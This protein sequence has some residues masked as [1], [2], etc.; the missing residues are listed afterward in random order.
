M[1]NG[2]TGTNAYTAGK[3]E[4]G[5]IGAD[6]FVLHRE[7][8]EEIVPYLNYSSMINFFFARGGKDGIKKEASGSNEL[9]HYEEDAK[10]TVAVVTGTSTGGATAGAAATFTMTGVGSGSTWLQPFF[11]NQI[12]RCGSKAAGYVQA[13][14]TAITVDNSA[15]EHA[16]TVKPLKA[17]N[18]LD[19]STVLAAGQ[20]VH[21]LSE[22]T[23]DGGQA[24]AGQISKLIRYTQNMHQYKRKVVQY[25]GERSNKAMVNIDGGNYLYLRQIAELYEQL[26]VDMAMMS[27]FGEKADNIT[28]ANHPDGA[29]K[30]VNTQEG[31]EQFII[32]NS[33]I[34]FDYAAAF[35]ND[36]FIALDKAIDERKGPK[37]YMALVGIDLMH[38]IDGAYFTKIK[39]ATAFGFFSEDLE[40][41]KNI[42]ATL[43]FK[44]IKVGST[45]FHIKKEDIFSAPDLTFNTEY[46][47]FGYLIPKGV[48]QTSGTAEG[49][50]RGQKKSYDAM[51]IRYR[52]NQKDGSRIFKM[53]TR[54]P[55]VTGTDQYE[56]HLFS[57]MGIQFS[58]IRHFARIYT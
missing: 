17:A 2:T 39:D 33:G 53:F 32:N 46:P 10:Y 28:D 15:G 30:T 35:D 51:C 49:F 14:V 21:H 4:P 26:D 34:N 1:A 11:V 23:A 31:L 13:Q 38:A 45:T 24:S 48:Y 5:V 12:V 6:D 47:E 57:E 16:I 27:F 42:A 41:G 7:I 3:F 8:R 20:T 36:D 9:H 37:E 43:H 58:G 54:G 25:G 52:D 44:S 56:T 40:E 22:G 18:Q 55:E 50:M 29:G 19:P